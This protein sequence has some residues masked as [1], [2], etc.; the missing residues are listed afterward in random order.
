M[1]LPAI[2]GDRNKQDLLLKVS[3]DP[4]W[5]AGDTN[6]LLATCGSC[7]GTKPDFRH[8]ETRAMPS[9]SQSSVK[10]IAVGAL[11]VFNQN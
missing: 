11:R 1:K 2:Y 8:L 6:G 4:N 3:I 10:M 5:N 9:T 7:R